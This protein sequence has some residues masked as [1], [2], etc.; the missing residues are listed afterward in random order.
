MSKS[1][2]WTGEHNESLSKSYEDLADDPEHGAP[3]EVWEDRIWTEMAGRDL[4]F[5]ESSGHG[6]GSTEGSTQSSKAL[7]LPAEFDTPSEFDHEQNEKTEDDA[8][9]LCCYT[10]DGLWKYKHHACYPTG[11]RD[12]CGY[13]LARFFDWWVDEHSD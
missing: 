1:E 5:L 4:M 9:K 3:R 12:I 11:Y 6:F 8:A 2:I 10:R 7:H 13:C